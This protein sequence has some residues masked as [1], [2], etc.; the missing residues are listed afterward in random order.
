MASRTPRISQ[1]TWDHHKDTILSLYISSDLTLVRLVQAMENDHGFLATASQFEAQLRGWNARKYMKVHEWEGIIEKIDRLASQNVRSRVVISGHPISPD[2]VNRARRYCKG[3]RH[4]KKRRREETEFDDET[5][6]HDTSDIFIETQDQNGNWCRHTA[7]PDASALPP[8]HQETSHSAPGLDAQERPIENHDYD[9]RQVPSGSANYR[10]DH[11]LGP[12]GIIGTTPQLAS[13]LVPGPAFDTWSGTGQGD[14]LMQSMDLSSAALEAQV[15]QSSMQ[16]ELYADITSLGSLELLNPPL[17]ADLTQFPIPLG[18]MYLY[19]LPFER[20]ERESALGRLFAAHPSPMQDCRLLFGAQKLVFV[21][22]HKAAVAMANVNERSV[23]ENIHAAWLTLQTLETNIPRIRQEGDGNG[24]TRARQEITEAEL[25]RLLLFSSANGFIGMGD[26]P[27]GAVFRFFNQDGKIIPLLSRLF[28]DCPGHVAKSLAENLFRAAIESGDHQAVRFF[29]E[30]R[31][32]SADNTF[33]FVNGKKYTPI[34]R[35]AELQELKVVHELLQFKPNVNKTF[36]KRHFSRPYYHVDCM[37]AL[38]CLIEGNCPTN[39]T[40]SQHSSFSSEYIEAVDALIRAGAELHPSF[41]AVALRRFARM[42]LAKK[43]FGKSAA[44]DHSKLMERQHL[45]SDLAREFPDEDAKE[46]TRKILSDCE[47]VGCGKC[48]SRFSDEVNRAIVG[49]ARRGHIQFV[50]FLFQYAKSPTQILSAAIRGGNRELIEFVL[51]QK[52]DL[53][54]PVTESLYTLDDRG[55]E[56]YT[57][58]LAEAIATR[59]SLL[60]EVLKRQGAFEHFQSVICAAAEVVDVHYVKKLLVQCPP[61][62][63]VEIYDALSEAI[64]S[65]RE[66]IVQLLL[67]FGAAALDSMGLGNQFS[68]AFRGGNKSIISSLTSTF[69]HSTVQN[70]DS[71]YSED[72]RLGNVEMLSFFRESGRLTSRILTHSIEILVENAE[73]RRIC[74]LFEVGDIATSSTMLGSAVMRNPNLLPILL[75]HT[76][77]TK[78][79]MKLFGTNAVNRAVIQG[80]IEAL[81]MLLDCGAVDFKSIEDTDVRCERK[82]YCAPFAEAIQRD[83]ISQCREFLFTTR[84]LAAGCDVNGIVATDYRGPR[85]FNI[86]PL[87]EA[88]EAGSKNLV[89]FLVGHGADINKDAVNRIQRTPLQAAAEKGKLDIVEWLLRNGADVNGKPA[90]CSGGTALQFAAMCGNCNVAMLLL[91]Y[92]AP[93]GAPPSTFHGRWP[94]EAA[95]EHG[96]LDMIK[97]LWNA[98]I[99]GFPIEMCNRAMQLAEENGHGAC[100][101]LIQELVAK[102]GI[103][104]ML[105]GPG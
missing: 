72:L 95:A 101:D 10:C 105:G 85:H 75:E 63:G 44:S 62:S 15:S 99:I 87:L 40:D 5:N 74:Q 78:S 50:R 31:L 77:S 47:Q 8:Q 21:F 82:R 18:V 32:V 70:L 90:E 42:D 93:L 66:D 9:A 52:P 53:S 43:L 16:Q 48:L 67:D 37:S 39:E 65:Q 19:D 73:Y 1:T 20:F 45:L 49:G 80:N 56:I 27:I 24:M 76:P 71:V 33:C 30:R 11:N 25:H 98:S 103:M 102:F 13:F 64:I 17:R 88:I 68:Q 4:S 91:D 100:K 7:T 55:K 84:L 3:E 79:C 92:G 89:Q 57:T 61:A 58:P 54:Q 26:I 97:L 46:A 41:I 51:A 12:P 94:L 29:L 83:A 59:D 2:R 86:T 28:R 14:A 38:G 35:A 60:I 69:P 6:Q 96:R 104:P 23:E 34:Q 81:D 36:F 22:M